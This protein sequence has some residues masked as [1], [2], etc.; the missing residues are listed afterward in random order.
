MLYGVIGDYQRVFWGA[1]TQ[2]AGLGRVPEEENPAA[3][4][5]TGRLW[6][7]AGHF[8]REKAC[9]PWRE[10]RPFPGVLAG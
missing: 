9:F 6:L 8:G 3:E 5:R 10:M 2:A 4:A 1:I 7:A